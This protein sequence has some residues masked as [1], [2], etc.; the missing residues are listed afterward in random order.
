MHVWAEYPWTNP[1]LIQSTLSVLRSLT[2]PWRSKTCHAQWSNF[3]NVQKSLTRP[4]HMQTQ[5]TPTYTTKT[6]LYD[7]IVLL[8]SVCMYECCVWSK[9]S[10]PNQFRS[11]WTRRRQWTNERWSLFPSIY[12]PLQRV[13]LTGPAN[14]TTMQIR[15]TRN[16]YT[17]HGVTSNNNMGY[18]LCLVVA[19]VCLSVFLNN[20]FPV[21]LVFLNDGERVVLQGRKRRCQVNYCMYKCIDTLLPASAGQ[22]LGS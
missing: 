13:S 16:I 2:K 1:I 10:S 8:L 22:L 12:H 18:I 20:M 9:H 6:S 19:V 3:A 17:D 4:I 5:N 7:V 11:N 15:N 21:R 14:K